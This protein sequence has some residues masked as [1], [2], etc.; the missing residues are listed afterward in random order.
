M[1]TL[2][3][4]IQIIQ[5]DNEETPEDIFAS[6]PGLI[7]TDDLRTLHGDP[8]TTI[9]YKSKRFGDIEL[10][11]ADPEGEDDRR[12]FSHYLWNAGI[13]L[14]ELISD[15]EAENG[16]WRVQGER[17]LE[18]GAGV[19][20]GGIVA[21]L[22][23]ADEVMITDY[24]AP[25]VIE[26]IRRNAK[27]CISSHL[28]AKYNIEGHRWGDTSSTTG[29]VAESAHHCTRIIAADCYWMLGEH[30]NL[31]RSMLHFLTLEPGG[32]VFAIGAFHTGRAKMAAF[33]D[34]ATEEGLEV[35][36]IYEEDADG[37][38]RAWVK[39]RNGGEED[40]LERKRWLVI[41]RLKRRTL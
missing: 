32:R 25:V 17:V 6:A 7:F 9:V 16:K 24:P 5:P 37:N 13:K 1:S 12:L 40:V 14:A 27:K 3:D 10:K 34:V 15:D 19:G 41:A 35:D 38:R 26:N 29:L 8:G 39:E 22:A 33:F 30:L 11:T 31:V 4:L 36:E 20:L 23:G 18:L 2:T 21:T 28:E